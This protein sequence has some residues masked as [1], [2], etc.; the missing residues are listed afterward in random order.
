MDGGVKFIFKTLVKVPI[1]I[2]V[3][4]FVFNIFSFTLTYFKLQSFASVVMQTAVKNN[5]LPPSEYA[6]LQASLADIADTGVIGDAYI[7]IDSENPGVPPATVKRQYGD[8][9]TV[10]VSAQFRFIWP[11]MPREQLN[12]TSGRFNGYGA[13]A[14]SSFSGYASGGTLEQRRENIAKNESNL[15]NIVYT[16]PGMTYYPDMQ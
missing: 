5:Y 14:T 6:T 15:I 13:G 7:V 16:V 8:P 2:F 12:N 11:L 3:S 10:G 4:F 1:I 9:V